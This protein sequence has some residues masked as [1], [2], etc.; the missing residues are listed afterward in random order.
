MKQFVSAIA[1]AALV[2]ALLPA[3]P[4]LAQDDD[5]E[6]ELEV[7][8]W[9]RELEAGLQLTQ[10]AY[11]NNWNGGDRGTIVWNALATGRLVGQPRETFRTISLGKLAYGQTIEQED[12]G[13]GDLDWSRP[14]KS[15]DR[16]DL[17]S[18]GLFTLGIWLDPFF[19]A[20]LESQFYDASDPF[21]RNLMFNPLVLK[22]TAGVAHQFLDEEDRSLLVRAGFSLRE[23]I[24]RSFVV[25][26]DP[27][28]DDTETDTTVDGGLELITDYSTSVF[29]DRVAW[30]SKLGLYQPLFYSGN[31]AFDELSG[32]QLQ[33]AGLDADIGDFTTTVDIDFENVLTSQITKYLS[34]N[35]YVRW[36]YDK[37]DNSVKP[38]LNEA[39]DGLENPAKVASAVRKAGQF[40]QTLALALTYRFF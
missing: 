37:Y 38:Q 18:I 21:D 39:G 13:S 25:P 17:E 26:D 2:V 3:S 15:T 6:E 11:S 31:D 7:G 12:D 10:S 20:R 22:E 16:I 5:E 34:V 23:N 19:S 24:R 28:V 40:K 32:A 35:L 36:L 27:A 14:F 8:E 4:V 9:T 33:A 1:A 30:T 29:D